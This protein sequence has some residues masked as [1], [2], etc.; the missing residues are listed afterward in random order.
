MSL[1]N[2]LNRLWLPRFS[3]SACMRGVMGRNTLGIDL[4]DLERFSFYPATPLCS[5]SWWFSGSSEMVR[6]GLPAALDSP[7]DKL[8]FRM[9]FAGPFTYPTISWNPGPA[10]GMMLLLPP[11]ALQRLAGIA[12]DMWV[13]RMVEAERVLPAPWLSMCE[14]VMASSHDDQRVR[15]IQD[16]LDPLWQEVRPSH[17]FQ[18]HRLHDWVYGLGLRAATSSKGRSLRQIE[19]RIKQWTGLPLRE[20]HVLARAEKAFFQILEADRRDNFKWVD[21]AADGGYADQSH[22]CRVSR[23]ITGFPPEELRRRMTVDEGF[24]AYRLWE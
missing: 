13:N 5:I 9:A 24:W 6:P 14:A 2:A 7:R 3:L 8:P 18:S 22:L 15:L 4:S 12:P 1:S 17:A 23:R 10:H 16:F 11:D 21:V 20:L 19:R